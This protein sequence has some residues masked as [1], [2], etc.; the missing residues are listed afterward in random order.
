MMQTHKDSD[1]QDRWLRSLQNKAD[2]MVAEKR[3]VITAGEDGETPLARWKARGLTVTQLADDE[4]GILRI[5]I[6]GGDG[7]PLELAYCTFRGRHSKCVDLLRKALVALQEG[8]S[9]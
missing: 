9:E 4:H 2:K 6:G 7:T 1:Y 3:S 8:S 5:S